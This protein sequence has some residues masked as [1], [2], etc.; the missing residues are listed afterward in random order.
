M[1]AIL[2]G[3]AVKDP[4]VREGAPGAGT[5]L[6]GAEMAYFRD[7]LNTFRKVYSVTG[8]LDQAPGLGPR[9]NGTSCAGCHSQ[10]AIGGSSPRRNPQLAMAQAHGARNQILPFLKP[11]GPVRIVRF[12]FGPGNLRDGQVRRLFTITGRPDAGGCVLPQPDFSDTNN[13]TFR[14][15]TPTFGAGLVWNIPDRAI[16]ANQKVNA[17]AKHELGI[18]GK[19]NR[20]GDG[21]VSRFGWKAQIASLLA[22]AGEAY[23]VEL[24]F[25]DEVLSYRDDSLLPPAC[26][27]VRYPSAVRYTSDESD[28]YE[29]SYWE[30]PVNVVQVASFMRFLDQPKAVPF[31]PGATAQSITRGKQLFDTVGCALCHTPTLRTGDSCGF[32][33]V[34]NVTA[35]LYSDLL[36]H[37]MGPGLA[38]GI[39]QGAAGADEFRTAPLWGVGQRVFFLHDGRTSDLLLA[40]REHKSGKG[41]SKSEANAVIDRFDALRPEEQQDILNF[42]RSL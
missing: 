21:A 14:I 6:A 27:A 35:N 13:M 33:A 15:P 22:F 20:A 9:F 31:F 34:N 42:L 23:A 4:G 28:G 7:G 10:P 16:L 25:S 3:A 2:W 30:P 36:V 8:M 39:I 18:V 1:T 29:Q 40:I 32:P 17:R 37:H 38:D 26:V 12:K 19:P 5:P 11:D 24:G 41:A